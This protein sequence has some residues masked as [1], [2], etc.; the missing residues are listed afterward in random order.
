MDMSEKLTKLKTGNGLTTEMLAAISGVPKGT[1]N[2]ILN[3]ET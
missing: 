1:I 2:K 3:G